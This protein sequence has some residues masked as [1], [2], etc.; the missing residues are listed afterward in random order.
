MELV[1][2]FPILGNGDLTPWRTS[3]DYSSPAIWM[4]RCWEHDV[5]WAKFLREINKPGVA[6]WFKWTPGLV[7]AYMNTNWFNKL[8]NDSYYGKMGSSS[9]KIIGYREAYPDLITRK[10]QTGFEKIDLLAEE[11]EQHL[12]KK[13]NGLP[14]RGSFDRTVSELRIELTGEV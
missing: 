13:Y 9:T 12:I 10:K 3:T 8:I 7:I 2:G 4:N 5:S 6:E 14:Y 1:D 11:M